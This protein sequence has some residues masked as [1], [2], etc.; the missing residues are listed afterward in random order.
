MPI[1]LIIAKEEMFA[2]KCLLLLFVGYAHG[3]DQ[4][5]KA[6]DFRV[7]TGQP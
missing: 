5:T 4:F 7:R 6:V 1:S 3:H 2:A